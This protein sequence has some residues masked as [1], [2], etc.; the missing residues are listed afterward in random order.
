M[1]RITLLA[2]GFVIGELL[3]S[4]PCQTAELGHHCRSSFAELQPLRTQPGL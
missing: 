4:S 1:I 2:S 3:L